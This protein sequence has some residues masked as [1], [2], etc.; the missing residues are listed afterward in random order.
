MVKG[1]YIHGTWHVAKRSVRT[2]TKTLQTGYRDCILPFSAGTSKG[3]KRH[4]QQPPNTDRWYNRGMILAKETLKCRFDCRISPCFRCI[5]LGARLP[6][7]THMDASSKNLVQH[8]EEN[9]RRPDWD[10]FEPALQGCLRVRLKRL[11]G[12]ESWCCVQHRLSFLEPFLFRARWLIENLPSTEIVLSR[13]TYRE[14]VCASVEAWSECKAGPETVGSSRMF[15]GPKGGGSAS[16][17][18]ST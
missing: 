1:T 12:C 15:F 16:V 14:K 13:A 9:E 6:A 17:T 5:G 18:T 2:L 4:I 11:S 8:C 10:C 3:A 7:N